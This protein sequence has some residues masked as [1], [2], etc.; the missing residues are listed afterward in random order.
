[1][2]DACAVRIHNAEKSLSYRVSLVCCFSKIFHGLFVRLR[3]AIA[4]EVLESG[5]AQGRRIQILFLYL[6]K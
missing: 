4:M 2:G 6:A 3:D 1:M 5:F